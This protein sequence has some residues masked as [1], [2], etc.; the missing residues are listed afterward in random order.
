MAINATNIINRP[1]AIYT[2]NFTG[3]PVLTPNNYYYVQVALYSHTS[4]YESIRVY[5][6]SNGG[7]ANGNWAYEAYNAW[8][9][10]NCTQSWDFDFHIYVWKVDPLPVTKGL[11]STGSCLGT[12]ASLNAFYI[13]PGNSATWTAWITATNTTTAQV[14]AIYS[15]GSK[16]LTQSSGTYYF[17]YQFN[18]TTTSNPGNPWVAFACSFNTAGGTGSCRYERTPDVE[19]DGAV[20]IL[21]VATCALANGSHPGD[22]KWN[23]NCDLNN[24]GVVDIADISYISF[25]F[26]TGNGVFTA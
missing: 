25:Y 19:H 11:S 26:G 1:P 18:T 4:P 10:C 15:A 16:L 17:V 22:S 6:D 13:T 9:E 8:W 5:G 2:F 20:N 14:F 3:F 24:D 12:A 7:Y 23:M 21:D